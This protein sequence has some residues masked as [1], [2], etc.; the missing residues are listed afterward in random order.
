MAS[1]I[2][3]P[4]APTTAVDLC[5]N[6]EAVKGAKPSDFDAADYVME[7][8][9]D[10]WRVLAHVTEDGVDLFTRTAS[11]QN[12]KLLDI[13]AEV[14]QLPPGTWIDGEVVSLEER[15]GLV[16]HEWGS[17]QKCLGAG[18]AKARL[19]AETMTFIAFDLIAHAGIDARSVSFGRRRQL[20]EAIFDKYEWEK[21]RLSPQL[22]PDDDTLAK[23]IEGGFEGAV[24]K[25]LASTY[26]SGQKTTMAG[27]KLKPQET[28]DFVVM[29]YKPG[30]NGFT[31]MVGAIEFGAY[32]ADGELV[33]V[34]RCSGM[35]M[36]TRKKLTANEDAYLGAVIEVKHM[37]KLGDHYRHPQFKRFRPDKPAT[38]CK[39]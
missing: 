17:V 20:L 7:P 14:G 6:A 39:A 21:V 2:A 25:P 4:Q 38:E 35:D 16:V 36:A 1:A 28:L 9:W 15:D 22:A 18:V 31:G 29:G 13:E 10:G 37:G 19:R 33:G 27:T 24:V 23:L 5:Q 12:G 8:K 34:G 3:V 32:D 11:P 30:Q 26:H